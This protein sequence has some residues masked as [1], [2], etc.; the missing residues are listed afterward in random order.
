[1]IV[2][3][4]KLR[5]AIAASLSI[6]LAYLFPLYYGIDDTSTAAITVMVIAT[7]DSL[8]SSI[9]KG[10][11]R[12]IGTYIG[13]VVGIT[14]IALFPQDR[15]LYLI[16][17]SI[18]VT[19]VLYFARAYRGDKTIFLLTAMTMMIVFDGGKVDDIFLYATQKTI[20]TVIGIVIYTFVSVYVIKLKESKNDDKNIF[21][22]VWFDIEDMKGA[23]ISFLVFWFSVYLWMDFEIVYGYY[24]I[25]LATSLSLYTTYSVAKGSTLLIVYTFSFIFAIFSYIFILPNIHG[26]WSLSVFLFLYSFVGFYF[27]NQKITLFYLLGMAT[28]LIENEMDFNFAIF[29][30]VLAIFYLFLFVLLIFDFFPFNQSSEHMFLKLKDR[31]L[32]MVEKN[33]NSIHLKETLRKM[34]F[35]SAKIDYDYFGVKKDDLMEF[36]R[37][38]EE[39]LKTKDIQKLYNYNIDFDRLKESKF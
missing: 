6:T 2:T 3:L 22:F 19:I 36:C 17:L 35:H 39:C 23:F 29:L 24:I 4:S 28:F 26:W 18:L 34:Q 9:Q 20:L 10:F 32:Y 11:Y 27:I 5:H 15:F 30:Y 16:V 7:A 1:M 31:F 25:I 33:P 13:A 21:K 38:C 12:V 37:A 8:G 14:L